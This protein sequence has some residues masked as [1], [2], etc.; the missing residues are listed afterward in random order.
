M[1]GGWL[2][3]AK[4]QV[5]HVTVLEKVGKDYNGVQSLDVYGKKKLRK[6]SKKLG[7]LDCFTI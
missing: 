6:N 1:N 7:K 3:D 4:R 2:S 5:S